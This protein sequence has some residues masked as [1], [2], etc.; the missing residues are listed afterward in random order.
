MLASRVREYLQTDRE[1]TSVLHE[2]KLNALKLC[3]QQLNNSISDA[4]ADTLFERQ[5]RAL[6][7]LER[8]LADGLVTDQ[9]LRE[10]EIADI[11]C[12]ALIEEL[13]NNIHS[14]SDETLK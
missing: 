10:R 11:S 6:I 9:A 1:T 5:N 14:E 8:S 12:D 3:E 7:E 2:R 4:K 13:S